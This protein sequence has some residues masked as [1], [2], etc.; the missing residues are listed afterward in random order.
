MDERG[1][2]PEIVSWIKITATPIQELEPSKLLTMSEVRDIL[3]PAC[4]NFMDKC[5]LM[6][7]RETG[8]RINEI[9]KANIEDVRFEKDRAYIKLLNSKR[10][11]GEISKREIV[12]IDSFYFLSNWLRDYPTKNNSSLPLFITDRN[13]RLGYDSVYR[14]LKKLEEETKINKNLHPH[15]FRHS[16]S[17]DMS[18]ILTDA[19]LRVFGG[20]VKTSNL[21][22]RYTHL[23]SEDVNKKRLASMGRIK[24]DEDKSIEKEKL[25]SCSR[26]NELIDINKFKFCGKCGMSLSNEEEIKSNIKME[27]LNKKVDELFKIF[28]EKEKIKILKEINKDEV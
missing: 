16:Q 4:H 13:K 9:L 21:I 23:T 12:L 22:A 19:E 18:K 14:L 8:G 26:C 2:Y 11:R 6:L 17:N 27:M 7:L 20:W 25:V 10:R 15:L 5:L 28:K 3:I 1:D 24:E